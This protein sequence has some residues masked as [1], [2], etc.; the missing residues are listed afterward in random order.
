MACL[1]RHKG[2]VI[3]LGI[4]VISTQSAF[5][6]STNDGSIYSRYGLG[7][8]RSF[9]SSQIQAMGGGGTGVWSYNFVNFSNPGSWSY[10]DPTRAAAGVRFDRI[11]ATDGT[12]STKRSM[13]AGALNAFQLSFPIIRHRLGLAFTFEPYSRVN[14]IVQTVG[15]SITDPTI[16]DSTLF[17]INYEGNGGLQK[18]RGGLGYRFSPNLSVGA[19]VDFIFGITEEAQRTRFLSLNYQ[20]TLVATSTRQIGLSGTLGLLYTKSQIFRESDNISLG[21]TLTLPTALDG[22]RSIVLG[23]SLDRDT[24]GVTLKGTTDLPLGTSFGVAYQNDFRWTFVADVRYE[25][26][27]KFK[28]DL[29]YPGY[30][31]VEGTSSFSDRLRVSAGAEWIPAGADF[32]ESYVKRIGY[33]LGVYYDQAYVSPSQDVD[34]NTIALTGGFSFPTMLPGSRFDLNF[35]IGR[36]GTTSH[37]LV[38]D[39][40]YGFSATLNVGERW[41]LDRKLN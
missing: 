37:N 7:E 10:Q 4:L 41:F 40:F 32:L 8:L 22:N 15:Q 5:A 14:Y 18:I 31:V 9:P 11:V 1:G 39:L 25:P 2:L 23:K 21:A 36:R 13:T 33:R 27:S 6:Q 30:N 35:E 3:L 16:L 34:L 12:N 20:E 29:F 24:L 38:Q 28:S 26:W 17:E 19:S